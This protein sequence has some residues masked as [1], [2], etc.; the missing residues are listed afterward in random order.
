MA[1]IAPRVG[2]N[3]SRFFPFFYV[4]NTVRE[5]ENV[6]HFFFFCLGH[7]YTQ[8]FFRTFLHISVLRTA[9]ISRRR[10][11]LHI[12]LRFFFMPVGSGSCANRGT[13]DLT[14]TYINE[15]QYLRCF[16]NHFCAKYHLN[17][18][19]KNFFYKFHR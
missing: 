9:K 13:N 12:F 2:P 17:W 3:D 6:E 5:P 15:D 11:V 10:A 1:G 19:K 4:Y 18:F 7:R 8:S 14:D 16:Y